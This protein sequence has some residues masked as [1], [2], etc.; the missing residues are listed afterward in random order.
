MPFTRPILHRFPTD[1]C[2]P[3]RNRTLAMWAILLST[4]FFT[5]FTPSSRERIPHSGNYVKVST[6]SA[7]RELI[8]ENCVRWDPRPSLMTILHRAH[9]ADTRRESVHGSFFAFSFLLNRPSTWSPF[10]WKQYALKRL[11]GSSLNS[12][13]KPSF[14]LCHHWCTNLAVTG[15]KRSVGSRETFRA[16]KTLNKIRENL[17]VSKKKKKKGVSRRC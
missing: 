13:W 12:P 6:V 16:A 8:D 15:P 17:V 3:K 11:F 10:S 4:E 14:D 1:I 5:H 9:Q 7:G 2:R